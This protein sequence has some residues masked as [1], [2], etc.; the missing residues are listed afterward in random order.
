M[1][2]GRNLDN[3]IKETRGGKREGSG[4]PKGKPTKTL[5]YRVPL[6]KAKKIDKEI[7][8]LINESR[9][10]TSENNKG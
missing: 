1:D 2:K 5:S 6:A 9:N 3:P 7:R 8:I 4:R 10:G